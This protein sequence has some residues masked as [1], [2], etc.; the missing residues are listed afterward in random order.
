MAASTRPTV[1]FSERAKHK[2]NKV[3]RGSGNAKKEREVT[4]RS[5]N[6]LR[7]RQYT[8]Q[9]PHEF[10]VKQMFLFGPWYK[11]LVP[12]KPLLHVFP[13]V[14]YSN[15]KQEVHS[16]NLL[17]CKPRWTLPKSP[18]TSPLEKWPI[19]ASLRPCKGPSMSPFRVISKT[20]HSRH[21]FFKSLSL[22]KNCTSRLTNNSHRRQLRL[23]AHFFTLPV[24]RAERERERE[25]EIGV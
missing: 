7:L 10:R 6:C 25:R 9:L 24:T 12:I 22:F 5:C 17:T 8:L 20:I 11:V 2:F 15:S 3:K 19:I 14:T 16:I 4:F 13:S 18:K 23:L 1:L 21:L